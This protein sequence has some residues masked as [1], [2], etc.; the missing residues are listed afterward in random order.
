MELPS[1]KKADFFSNIFA[2][3]ILGFVKAYFLLK[4]KDGS[5]PVVEGPNDKRRGLKQAR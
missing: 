4:S 5:L 3:L 2:Y 1:N